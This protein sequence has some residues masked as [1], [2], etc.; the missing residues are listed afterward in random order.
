MPLSLRTLLRHHLSALRILLVL[1]V[2]TGICYP[3]L[4]TGIAL[5]A[6][7][8]QA[9]GSLLG[10][11]GGAT[12]SRLIGQSFDLP[13]RAGRPG[14][15]DPKW[16]QPRPSAA[17]PSGYD[18][19]SS[20]AS[21]LGPNNPVL[22]RMI[23]ER[24]AAVAAFDGVPPSSVPADALTASGS[25]LDPHIS[26]AY[27]NQQVSRVAKVRGL[28]PA[29]VRKLVADHV[30]GRGGGFLGHGDVVNVVELNQDLAGVV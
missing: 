6:F 21:N 5:A 11:N 1:T 14:G 19:T 10:G 20:G 12:G 3:L 28:S 26:R 24:R 29:T 22:I 15:P 4:I 27:A 2:I 17:G 30:E 16:F 25:G 9:N 7:P 8:S 18:P 23:K 13:K